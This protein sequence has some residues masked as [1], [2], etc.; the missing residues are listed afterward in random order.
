MNNNNNNEDE[1]DK[2]DLNVYFLASSFHFLI[3]QHGKAIFK[4]QRRVN[5]L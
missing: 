2:D 4:S 1:K 5:P 3:E